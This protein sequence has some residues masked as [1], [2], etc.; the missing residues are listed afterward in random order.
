[1]IDRKAMQGMKGL[2]GQVNIFL[3]R[4][5]DEQF[6][7]KTCIALKSE[8]FD[9]KK[10]QSQNKSTTHTQNPC[11]FIFSNYTDFVLFHICFIT[12]YILL[13]L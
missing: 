3:K 5:L 8:N 6:K 13:N 9:M 1:M 7:D 12:F 4:Y 11:L 2:F 10:G